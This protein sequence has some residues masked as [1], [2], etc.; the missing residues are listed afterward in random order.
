MQNLRIIT[1]ASGPYYY[2]HQQVK[3]LDPENYIYLLPVN[4]AVRYFKKRLLSENPRTAMLDPN[5]Y[6]FNQFVNQIFRAM[7][8]GKKVINNAIQLLLLEDVLKQ[9]APDLEYFRSGRLTSTG[10]VRRIHQMMNELAQ[11]GYMPAKFTEA[12]IDTAKFRDF[13]RI[14][15][16]LHSRYGDQLLDEPLMMNVTVNEL[17]QAQFRRIFPEVSR[18]YVS[19]YGIYPPPMV[20]LLEKLSHWC[21]VTVK[22]D[23]DAKNDPGLFGHTHDAHEMLRQAANNNSGEYQ[24]LNEVETRWQQLAQS[25]FAAVHRE[26]PLSPEQLD[27]RIELQPVTNRRVEVDYIL[28]RVKQLVL[29]EKVPAS[30][31]GVTFANLE[32]Y[33]PMLRK[34]LKEH[35]IAFNLSTGYHLT[36]SP[37]MHTYLQVLKVVLSR[38]DS[39]AIIDLLASP[40]LR[41][42][43]RADIQVFKKLRARQRVSRLEGN[44]KERVQRYL[45][46]LAKPKSEEFDPDRKN[47]DRYRECFERLT[48]LNDLLQGMRPKYTVAEFR[49]AYLGVLQTLGLRDWNERGAGPLTTVEQEKEYRAFNKFMQL[50]GHFTF[51]MT[52]IHESRELE[53]HELT[54]RLQLIM[55]D[56]TYNLREFSNYGIQIMPRLEIQSA[57][58]EVLFIGGMIEGEFP[59]KYRHD[60]FFNDS[61]REKLGLIAGEDLVGQDRFQFYQLLA[62][63]VKK[64]HL[65][66]PVFE[67][68]SELLRS[69]FVDNLAKVVDVEFP[70][71]AGEEWSQSRKRVA[72]RIA[73]RMSS[74]LNPDDLQQL[75]FLSEAEQQHLKAWP[76]KLNVLAQQKQNEKIT[77]WEGNLSANPKITALLESKYAGWVYSA[78][79]L[80]IYSFC[81]MQYLFQRVF[82]VEEEEEVAEIITPL[83]KGQLLHTILYR[84]YNRLCELKMQTQPRKFLEL[85][86]SIAQDEFAKMPYSGLRWELVREDFFG[87][88]G[89][90]SMWEI[91]LD[92]EQ[93]NLTQFGLIPSYFELSFGATP[94]GEKD[95]ASVP[96]PFEHKRDDQQVRLKGK[97]DRL[98]LDGLGNMVVVDYKTSKKASLPNLRKV[99][100]GRSL[101]LPVYLKVAQHITKD[102]KQPVAAKYII[103][104]DRDNCEEKVVFADNEKMPKMVSSQSQKAP[105]KYSDELTVDELL[106]QSLNYALDYSVAIR[107]G[108]F[109]HSAYPADESCKSYCSFRR[110]CRKRASKQMS[111]AVAAAHGEGEES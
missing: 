13:N 68:E 106:E 52:M 16:A 20:A 89:A 54:D 104:R 50:F 60:I 75:H 94:G 39:D 53:L 2:F 97:I 26:K 64:V 36:Q 15:S 11:F 29:V 4:R 30:K 83:E 87:R 24:P 85:L 93:Q 111:Y 37:L 41:D 92:E 103:V 25:L 49:D 27:L 43:Y 28:N 5:I 32:T 21:R 105:S 47:Y 48:A 38:F 99:L 90:R 23:Y 45:D 88:E 58:C 61:E 31:I 110:I 82:R 73:L 70:G 77:A 71:V 19:G 1:G 102:G 65:T 108:L 51:V 42:E 76:E 107:E 91:L 100:D 101:Q 35:G 59:R 18:I 3:E 96:E 78:T 44:W 55:N 57:E 84:F 72:E 34:A 63:G 74:G 12:E 8:P 14:I 109:R 17:D 33:V 7:H 80:E 79:E 69:T 10:L 95:P 67:N 9:L 6:T 22:L 98:D 46:Y 40:F 56:A 86:E 66:W 62:G 81:P